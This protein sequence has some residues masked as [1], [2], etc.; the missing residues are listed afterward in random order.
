M[1]TDQES[2]YQA[3]ALMVRE[4]RSRS[5]EAV[6][7]LNY[8]RMSAVAWAREHRTVRY[9]LGRRMGHTAMG[10]RLALETATEQGLPSLYLV[11]S[12]AQRD[13]VQADV[14]GL[15]VVVFC[16]D[17]LDFVARYGGHV[18]LVVV[19]CA[20]FFS[21]RKLK[22]LWGMSHDLGDPMFVLLQ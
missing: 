20:T 8:E 9:A 19:D 21:P 2:L 13:E 17:E 10:V 14:A 12:P 5:I 3:L 4:T 7:Y 6:I 18:G 22:R 16:F 11:A 15:G 1:P